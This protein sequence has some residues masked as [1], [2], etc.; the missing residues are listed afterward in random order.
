MSALPSDKENQARF[1]ALPE[2]MGCIVLA[3]GAGQRM[4]HRPK[5]LLQL[6]GVSWIQQPPDYAM[7]NLGGIRKSVSVA[8]VADGLPVFAVMAITSASGAST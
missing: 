8:L 7:V 1:A 2:R 5:C 6:N 4:G 3:A